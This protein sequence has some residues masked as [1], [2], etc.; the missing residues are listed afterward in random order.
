M[1]VFIYCADIYCEKCGQAIRDQL[2]AENAHNADDYKRDYGQ[3]Y[4]PPNAET[5][6]TEY[7]S[8]EYPKGPFPDGGGEADCPQHCGNC[9]VFLENP[10]TS[11]GE[12]Y[13]REALARG[14]DCVEE[15]SRYYGITLES[16]ESAEGGAA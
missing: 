13:V 11:E 16:D 12:K 2:D 8:D 5:P 3:D 10:L 1:D 7:D 14:G 15:W 6:E 4:D 9:R